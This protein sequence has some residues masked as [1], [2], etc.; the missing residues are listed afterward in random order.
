MEVCVGSYWSRQTRLCRKGKDRKVLTDVEY[1]LEIKTSIRDWVDETRCEVVTLIAFERKLM[2]HRSGRWWRQKLGRVCL[3]QWVRVE[4]SLL[5][6]LLRM[7]WRENNGEQA[8]V[9]ACVAPSL[10]EFPRSEDNRSEWLVSRFLYRRRSQ[11]WILQQGRQSHRCI[12][13]HSENFFVYPKPFTLHTFSQIIS[14]VRFVSIVYAVTL[15]QAPRSTPP[16][17][18][19]TLWS[20]SNLP[21]NELTRTLAVDVNPYA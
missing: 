8:W 2:N 15:D 17:F 6:T 10:R 19:L 20:W 1:Q 13:F 3:E 18:T 14:S 4:V 5:Y 9:V 16:D 11:L 21:D 12:R 7:R